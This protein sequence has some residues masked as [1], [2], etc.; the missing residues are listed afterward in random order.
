MA[1]LCGIMRKLYTK[2]VIEIW[3]RWLK[4]CL[5]ASLNESRF[6]DLENNQLEQNFQLF[7]QQQLKAATIRTSYLYVAS[8][9]R[10]SAQEQ[11]IQDLS[12]LDEYWLGLLNTY[13]ASLNMAPNCSMQEK[14]ARF[15]AYMRTADIAQTQEH[16]VFFLKTLTALILSASLMV[17]GLLMLMSTLPVVCGTAVTVSGALLGF[18]AYKARNEPGSISVQ[19]NLRA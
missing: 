9:I 5:E 3:M 2:I 10:T 17:V 19:N 6:I 16:P 8:C 7:V 15:R 12:Q 1:P 4:F 13:I 11:F 14:Q 18:F